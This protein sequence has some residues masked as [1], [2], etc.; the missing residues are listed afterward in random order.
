MR[1]E[2]R[3]SGPGRGRAASVCCLLS[4]QVL[5]GHCSCGAPLGRVRAAGCRRDLSKRGAVATA[6]EAAISDAGPDGGP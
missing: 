3:A 4:Q 2:S 1:W 5:C 6:K